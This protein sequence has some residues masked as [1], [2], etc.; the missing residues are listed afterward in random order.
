[1]T[2]HATAIVAESAI[3]DN[4]VEVGPYTVIGDGVE[5]GAGTRIASHVVINGPTRIGRDNRIYQFASIGD[6]PQDKKYANEPTRLE[7]GERNTIREYCTISRGTV[8]DEGL[9]ALGDDNWIMAY[10]HIAHD[11]RIGNHTIFANNATLA[12]HVHVG[13]WV[14]FAGFSGAHQFCRIGAHSFLGMYC[15]T[16]RDVPAYTLMAGQ[17]A[18][19]RGINSEGLKR[20]GFSSEQ[21]R[22]IKNAYRI[23][24]RKGLKLA[25]AIR[26]IET[27]VETQPELDIFLE[28]LRVSDR[29]LVR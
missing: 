1:L 19:P 16:N 27:L 2:I 17:P 28:S 9:T 23:V 11:C 15:G 25:Q 7:I 24:Y 18:E 29:G 4:D 6:D 5:I 22:N 26:E 14:I 21:V 20:R 13:D 10:V 3:L 12:G 8:Q